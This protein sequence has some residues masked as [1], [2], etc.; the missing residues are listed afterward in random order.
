M[1]GSMTTEGHDQALSVFE[2]TLRVKRLLQEDEV[3]SGVWVKGEISNL[4]RAA[5]GHTYFTLKDDRAV[6]KATLWA[7]NRKRIKTDFKSGDLVSAFGSI[8]VYEPRGEYQLIVSDLKPAGIGSLFEAFEKLK[9]K[10]EAEGLFAPERKVPLPFLPRGVGVVTSPKGAVIQDIFRVIR[11]RFPNMPIFLVPAKVQGEGSAEEVAEGLR[12]LDADP[13]IDVIIVARGGGSIED[14][15][16]FNE[17]SVARAIAAAV[18]PVISAVG[19][20]TDFTI[21][22]FVADKRAATPS[23]AG[24]LVVPVKEDLIR[25]VTERCLRIGR[26]L[27]GMISIS[28][29]ILRKA[30]AC[31]FLRQPQLLV[32]ERKLLAANLLRDLETRFRR[33]VEQ[34]RNRF[35]VGSSRLTALNPL[36]VLKRGF[37]IASDEN[38]A[39]LTSARDLVKGQ[40]LS[41]QFHDGR[42]GTRIESV[43]R[44]RKEPKNDEESCPPR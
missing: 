12:R 44:N 33:V 21:A 7:G 24:E 27:R 43:E 9:R 18:K 14:L 37:S 39:V 4:T 13:R 26:S 20:E 34:A 2:L 41:L 15:W 35:S 5:S 8:S 22:D 38:G 42:A 16:T 29:Q 31:R 36:A 6:L 25:A 40:A 19:H 23:V 28:R 11:R 32:A 1:E 3:L 30:L 17:E 10:L